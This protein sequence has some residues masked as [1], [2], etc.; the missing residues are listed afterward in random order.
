MNVGILYFKGTGATLNLANLLGREFKNHEH[1]VDYIRI[2]RGGKI[3][4][5]S[6]DLVGIGAPTYSFR[7]PRL[8]TTILKKIKFQ[9]SPFFVFCTSGGM[10]GNTLWNIYKSVKNGAGRYLGS[11]EVSVYTNLRS[12][13][14]RKNATNTL[15]F[16]MSSYYQQSSTKFIQTILYKIQNGLI[17]GNSP[18]RNVF[19]SIWS[20]FFTWRWEMAATVGIKR[21][22]K[23][24]CNQCGLCVENICPSKAIKINSDKYPHFNEFNCV[25][26]NGCVNL[27]PKDAIW[28]FQ[29]RNHHQYD[30]FRKDIFTIT[31]KK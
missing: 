29:T 28:S 4:L 15:S 9:R 20:L 13:M 12:W 16:Q 27:C 18:S 17:S 11:F 5:Q 3:D 26:C 22:D 6:Y 23:N 31:K 25:G 8:V 30:P 7:A 10:S 14:P 2:K 21:I 1:E 24:L 19:T